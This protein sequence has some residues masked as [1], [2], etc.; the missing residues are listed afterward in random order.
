M[1]WGVLEAVGNPM[2]IHR[3]FQRRNGANLC[4]FGLHSIFVLENDVEKE[5][6]KGNV[7]EAG[8]GQRR[9][10]QTLLGETECSVDHWRLV[11]WVL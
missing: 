6:K 11:I 10:R 3:L 2:Q 1:G 4:A 5:A 7:R 9:N 8:T